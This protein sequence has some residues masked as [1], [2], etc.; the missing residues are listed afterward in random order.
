MAGFHPGNRGISELK[1][2][3]EVAALKLRQQGRTY[4]QIAAELDCSVATALKHVR[5]SLDRIAKTNESEALVLRTLE[6]SRLDDLYRAAYEV[7]ESDHYLVSAGKVV[8]HKEKELIDDAPV[9][10]AIDRLVKISERRCALLGLDAPK[11]ET[12]AAAD[13]VEAFKQFAEMAPT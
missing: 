8:E 4:R 3:R 12:G 10:R 7:L 13:L 2:E 1:A 5:D 9:L 11:Q 6:L